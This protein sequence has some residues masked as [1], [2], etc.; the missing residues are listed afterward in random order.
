MASK[1]EVSLK[2]LFVIVSCED[3]HEAAQEAMPNGVKEKIQRTRKKNK[4]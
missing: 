2:K 3:A 4:D 1:L